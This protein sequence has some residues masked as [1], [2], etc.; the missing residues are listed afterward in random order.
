MD[1]SS[2]CGLSLVLSNLYL[3]CS[4]KHALPSWAMRR[5]RSKEGRLL[6]LGRARGPR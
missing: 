1:F 2:P 4:P 5:N 6:R 3:K